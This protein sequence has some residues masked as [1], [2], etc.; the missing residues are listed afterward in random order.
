[1]PA[2]PILSYR[3][4]FK[5][6]RAQVANLLGCAFDESATRRFEIVEF[7]RPPA[8]NFRA[9][10]ALALRHLDYPLNEGGSFA[11][12][13]NEHAERPWPRSRINCCGPE[14]DVIRVPTRF[15]RL[16]QSE[17]R[18]EHRRF[19]PA[20]LLVRKGDLLMKEVHSSLPSIHAP[21]IAGLQNPG[22]GIR[23]AHTSRRLNRECTVDWLEAG[24]DL[25]RNN[26]CFIFFAGIWFPRCCSTSF[27]NGLISR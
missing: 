12:R 9:H 26:F 17:S 15:R 3:E 8:L 23:P 24:I 13:S 18:L 20:M 11:I 22:G 19:L 21:A 10:P 14:Y 5:V 4:F 16:S 27:P 6:R 25:R 2:R 7:V 1:M